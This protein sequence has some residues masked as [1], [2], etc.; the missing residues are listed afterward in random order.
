MKTSYRD[1]HAAQG[2]HLLW[3]N[4]G[5]LSFTSVRVT[6]S[7]VVP[8]R[9]PECPPMS[10]AWITTRYSSLA[11]LSILGRAVFIIAEGKKMGEW[12]S[13]SSFKNECVNHTHTHTHTHIQKHMHIP[14]IPTQII[15]C[16]LLTFSWCASL[17]PTLRKT[18]VIDISGLLAKVHFIMYKKELIKMYIRK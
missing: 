9:P 5:G 15:F 14:Q 12:L 13:D 2:I 7:V 1:A 17:M 3:A 16:F 6:V 4:F 8:D 18:V 10:L 11:S